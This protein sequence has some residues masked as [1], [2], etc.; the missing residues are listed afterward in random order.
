[1]EERNKNPR[2]DISKK[3]GKNGSHNNRN[4]SQINNISSSI[5]KG[6]SSNITKKRDNS[7]VQP[8]R[9][10]KE[11]YNYKKR[12]SRTNNLN[13]QQESNINKDTHKNNLKKDAK[14]D[15]KNEKTING[16]TT[17][18]SKRTY[19]KR[20]INN[21][22]TLTQND[23]L[24]NIKLNSNNNNNN[25]NLNRQANNQRK[26]F[27]SVDKRM[28]FNKLN[29]KKIADISNK[30]NEKLKEKEKGKIKESDIIKEN[31][32][33]FNCQGKA[34]LKLNENKFSVNM[35]CE[36][37]HSKDNMPIKEFNSKN[38]LKKDI[39]C[40]ECRK[41]FNPKKLYYCSCDKN[42]CGECKRRKHSDHFQ[43]YF[44][45]K[46]YYC[47][48]HRQKYTAYCK[49]CKKNICNECLREHSN[50]NKNVEY[51]VNILPKE[52]DIINC[53]SNLEKIKLKKIE[54]MRKM[55]KYIETL[56]NKKNE[57]SQFFENFLK[58]Q[59]DIINSVNNINLNYEEIMN[60][61]NLNKLYNKKEKNNIEEYLDISNNF[62][63]EGEYLT[64]L[65]AGEDIEKKEKNKNK[66]KN[67]IKNNEINFS[68]INKNKNKNI[69]TSNI[70]DN[71]NIQKKASDDKLKEKGHIKKQKTKDKEKEKVDNKNVISKEPDIRPDLIGKIAVLD[72]IETCKSKLDNRDERCITSFAI[73]RNNRI[74]ITFKGGII[75]IYE[76][77][78]NN[79][80]PSDIN[81]PNE[82]QLKEILR[83]EEDE[84][85]FN[86]GIEF[87]NGNL[88]V[89]SEDG[90]VK[91]IK[92]FFDEKPNSK[93][94]YK[95]IQRI[96]EKNQDPIYTMKELTNE[97]FVLG[98]WKN[99]LVYQKADE[100]ELINKIFI[101]DYTF[102]IIELSPNEII[103]SHTETK[104]LT[105]HNFNNYDT[106]TINNIES[107]ENNNIICKYNNKNDIIF[108]AYNNGVNIVSII[109][110]CLLKKIE[111]NEIISGLCPMEM[112]LSTGDGKTKKI[113]GLICGAKRQIYGE[114]VNFAYSFLQMGFNIN[115][116][117]K[118]EI[119]AKDDK[120]IKFEI[121]S[122][123]DRIHYYD[124]NN[125]INTIF[126]KNNDTL[127]INENKNEQWIFSSGNEDKKLRIWK[128]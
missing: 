24:N 80:S 128:L 58:L 77:E 54:C 61:K 102:S 90:T 74:L 11:Y 122:R 108:V 21:T 112:T 39:T 62:V 123:K 13:I 97:N 92:L 37:G 89:C 115:K 109:N 41:D 75:K 59:E 113:F 99:I 2:K 95:I 64:K 86:Y 6:T 25:R 69:N 31:Y 56:K 85:C 55:D 66:I 19:Q 28:K 34:V 72:K 15:N 12:E 76:L 81:N 32:L 114:N 65:L 47:T 84:Y 104:T 103:S 100:Y 44:L 40:N 14:A 51:F 94:K 79:N 57:F 117:D 91:I 48:E 96:E 53:K 1:M 23:N 42:I 4:N 73:L 18:D 50:H 36:N 10:N 26:G 87:K 16:L 105:V 35:T 68:I 49:K 88:G 121:I 118:G 78:K 106:Y 93:E 33:C 3:P 17:K 45:E 52:N 46:C 101:G 8:P 27:T 120:D 127:K 110:K 43:V 71:K 20:D 82:I 30:E 111:L 63:N 126:C 83:L 7:N 98:C 119:N 125:I 67:E 29:S 22:V 5:H 107:N 124:V 116:V 9:G 60:F 38:V 70:K